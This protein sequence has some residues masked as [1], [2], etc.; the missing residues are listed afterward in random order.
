MIAATNPVELLP[1]GVLVNVRGNANSLSHRK[2]KSCFH[3][4]AVRSMSFLVCTKTTAFSA[5]KRAAFSTPRITACTATRAKVLT[6]RNLPIRERRPIYSIAK[7]GQCTCCYG[8]NDAQIRRYMYVA[9]EFGSP[10]NIL[11]CMYSNRAANLHT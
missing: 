1:I 5:V 11:N 3:P 4:H 10:P 6:T 8:F 2:K 7:F 9:H